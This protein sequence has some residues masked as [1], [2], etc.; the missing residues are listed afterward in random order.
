MTDFA[1]RV[2]NLSKCYQIYD[3]PRDRLKQFVV[4]KLCRAIPALSKLFPT[5][6][7]LASLSPLT[8]ILVQSDN[9]F[10]KATI[11]ANLLN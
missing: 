10:L 4:P 11:D 2:Q 6:R 3:G 5:N 8:P 9:N 1:I 7:P